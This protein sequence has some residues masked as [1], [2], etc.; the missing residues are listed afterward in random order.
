MNSATLGIIGAALEAPAWASPELRDSPASLGTSISPSSPAPS[1]RLYNSFSLESLTAGRSLT[2][3]PACPV[4]RTAE[5]RTA[6]PSI[7]PRLL[8]YFASAALH[9]FRPGFPPS[10]TNPPADV[11]SRGPSESPCVTKSE[12]RLRPCQLR[13]NRG[14]PRGSSDLSVG[15]CRRARCRGAGRR[16]RVALDPTTDVAGGWRRIRV[17]GPPTGS[18]DFRSLGVFPAVPWT[19][20]FQPAS[21][22]RRRGPLTPRDL[23][24]GPLVRRNS[25]C[26]SQTRSVNCLPRRHAASISGDSTW[27]VQSIR[28]IVSER[29]AA[30]SPRW[31][32]WPAPR[33]AVT[34]TAPSHRRPIHIAQRWWPWIRR[35]PS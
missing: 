29:S 24:S 13:K 6:S 1:M 35:R 4:S 7:S 23:R 14:C 20:F 17:V 26:A 3:E 27:P 19:P 11:W 34:A 18:G 2:V 31:R 33:D 10:R 25:P 9:A 30:C 32:P 5:P 15:R 16:R 21:R 28:R 22:R 8:R 12:D